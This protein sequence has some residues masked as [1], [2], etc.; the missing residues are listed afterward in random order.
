MSSSEASEKNH[1]NDQETINAS[2]K[3]SGKKDLLLEEV[4]PRRA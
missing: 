2:K 3:G 4:D 1:M